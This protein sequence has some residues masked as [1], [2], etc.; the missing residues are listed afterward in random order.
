V[1]DLHD[2]IRD[3]LAADAD[4]A[5]DAPLVWS[6]PTAAVNSSSPR[7]P[8]AW[9]AIAAAGVLVI[10]G[11]WVV[12]RRD[13]RDAA[14]PGSTTIPSGP[15]T[16]DFSG[17]HR[18]AMESRFPPDPDVPMLESA[19]LGSKSGAYELEFASRSVMVACMNQAGFEFPLPTLTRAMIQADATPI[20][21]RL[22]PAQAAVNGYDSL[23]SPTDQ[24]KP[25]DDY[26]A[27]LDSL[28]QQAFDAAAAE[29]GA[30]ARDSAFSDF[31]AYEAARMPMEEQRNTF[32]DAFAASTPVKKLDAEWS[33]CMKDK[34]YDLANIQGAYEL[35]GASAARAKKV[36][37]ADADCRVATHYEATY[38]DLYRTAESAFVYDHQ[39][40]ILHLLQLR[41][42]KLR[43]DVASTGGTVPNGTDAPAD[44]VPIG[45]LAPISTTVT[46]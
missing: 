6:G 44:N 3:A 17:T 23:S 27:T 26:R 33:T 8:Y 15:M 18:A 25:A 22:S 42:G 7:R 31:R 45:T 20:I 32:I 13:T 14:R 36:A 4:R 41:Y 12:T 37:I 10:A 2:S 28:K 21:R 39:A 29:C 5:P 16:I 38:I 24:P 40:A 46:S 35:A 19:I 34:G 1:N 43:G 30:K 11:L 9:L